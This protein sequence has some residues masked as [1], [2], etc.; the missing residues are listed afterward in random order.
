[1]GYISGVWSATKNYKICLLGYIPSFS[2]LQYHFLYAPLSPLPYMKTY[3]L[4]IVPE[5]REEYRAP[6]CTMYVNQAVEFPG[7][8]KATSRL[9]LSRRCIRSGLISF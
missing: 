1:M 8:I 6:R 7:Q 2:Q 4:A 9:F 5:V 3:R